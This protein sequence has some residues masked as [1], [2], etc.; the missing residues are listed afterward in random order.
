MWKVEER[1]RT[2]IEALTY[3]GR[4]MTSNKENAE[5]IFRK[6][7]IEKEVEVARRFLIRTQRMEW[8]FQILNE[9]IQ[10]RLW[11]KRKRKWD[12]KVG[13]NAS[14]KRKRKRLEK[15]DVGR[16]AYCAILGYDSSFHEEGCSKI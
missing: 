15:L 6:S 3:C 12:K 2:Y 16:R 7:H 11:E 9:K 8:I 13:E 1:D 14:N 4:M 10:M 5:K